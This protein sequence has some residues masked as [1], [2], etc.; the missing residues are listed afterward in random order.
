MRAPLIATLAIL[1]AAAGAVTAK[2]QGEGI[3]KIQGAFGNTITETFPDG[4]TSRVWLARDGSY[5][6]EGRRHDRSSGRWSV[7]GTRLCF[8]QTHPFVFGYTFC[9]PI[10]D[11]GMGQSWTAR[12]PTGER[13]TVKVVEGHATN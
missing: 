5:T 4:R 9:T 8:K 10:P 6:G 13:I 2:P 3:A 1:V 12:A 11:V 7:R